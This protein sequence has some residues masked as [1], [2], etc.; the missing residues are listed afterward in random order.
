MVSMRCSAI[1]KEKETEKEKEKGG[2]GKEETRELQLESVL[3]SVG[4]QLPIV[5]LFVTQKL[6]K[7]GKMTQVHA[8]VLVVLVI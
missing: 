6:S 3:L 8:V 1:G 7:H 5:N 2:K 4:M